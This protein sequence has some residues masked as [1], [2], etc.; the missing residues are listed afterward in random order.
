MTTFL[1]LL[2]WAYVLVGGIV[3]GWVLAHVLYGSDAPIP[4]DDP[5]LL[6]NREEAR[7]RR[8]GRR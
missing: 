1:H 4:D 5:E 8:E 2:S 7:Q 3:I 6:V